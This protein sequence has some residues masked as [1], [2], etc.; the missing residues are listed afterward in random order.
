MDN[1]HSQKTT[2]TA[3][4]AIVAALALLG[5]VVVIVTVTIPQQQVEAAKPTVAPCATTPGGNA[6]KAQCFI[7]Y[8][9]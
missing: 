4:I 2:S 9:F 1:D 8:P 6:S 3:I 7:A 5:V